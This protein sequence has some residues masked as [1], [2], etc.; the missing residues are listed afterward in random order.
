MHRRMIGFHQDELGDWV[1]GLDCL[2]AQHVRHAP[3]FREAVWVTD[4]ATRDQ[5]LGQP[6]DCPL[7]DRA[8]LPEDLQ[9]VRTTPTWDRDSTPA[10]LLASHRVAP[11]TWGLLTVEHGTLRFLAGTSPPLDVEVDASRPQPIPPDVDHHVELGDDVRFTVT[12]LR[13]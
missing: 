11:G 2:H 6:L 12:F 7:C 3:P 13:R 10:A 5:R 9:P 8:E 4:E 1:A